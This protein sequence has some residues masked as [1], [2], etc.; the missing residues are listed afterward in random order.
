MADFTRIAVALARLDALAERDNQPRLVIHPGD[1]SSG[2]WNFTDTHILFRLRGDRPPPVDLRRWMQITPRPDA[3]SV[4]RGQGGN[5]RGFRIERSGTKW[6]AAVGDLPDAAQS[7]WG[8]E[9]LDV[10]RFCPINVMVNARLLRIALI[11]AGPTEIV[12]CDA[13]KDEPVWL[14]GEGWAAAIAHLIQPPRV[15]SERIVMQR[16]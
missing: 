7:R 16:G 15:R 14:H 12:T 6:R 5:R 8:E 10:V 9:G 3:P 1:D 13:A 2:C 4:L 11:P